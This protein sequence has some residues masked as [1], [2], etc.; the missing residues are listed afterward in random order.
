MTSEI[1][2]DD[3]TAKI[4]YPQVNRPFGGST[5]TGGGGEGVVAKVKANGAKTNVD[6][7]KKPRKVSV[8]VNY[9]ET[10]RIEQILP[11][12]TLVYGYTCLKYGT[13]TINDASPPVDV[14]TR[15]ADGVKAGVHVETVEN[16]VIMVSPKEGGT[17]TRVLGIAV[18]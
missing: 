10:N 18:K 14:D 3:R 9:K 17:P 16:I 11:N 8:C 4:N 13:E 1:T 6:F 7:V 12:G 15:Y 2:L 5:S